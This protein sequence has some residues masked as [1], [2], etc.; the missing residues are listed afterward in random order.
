MNRTELAASARQLLITQRQGVL[1]TVSVKVPGYPFGSL[2]PYALDDALRPIFLIS[3][4]AVHTK[5]A[6][7][8]ARASLCIVEDTARLTLVGDMFRL[9]DAATV[10]HAYLERHPEA[11][12]W[13]GFGDFAFWRLETKAVYYVAGFGA[14]GW[15]EPEALTTT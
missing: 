10:Q 13:A 8:D 14:M 1:A 15:I 11:A 5:N 2:M 12:Q 3:G 7:A 4:L 6:L 9:D